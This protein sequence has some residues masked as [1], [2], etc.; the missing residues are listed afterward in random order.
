MK[1]NAIQRKKFRVTPHSKHT[2]LEIVFK[3]FLAQVEKIYLFMRP[4]I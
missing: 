4:F 2:I 3:A 1:L